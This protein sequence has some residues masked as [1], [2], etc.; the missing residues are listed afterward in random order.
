MSPLD[1]ATRDELIDLLAPFL[2]SESDRRALLSTALFGVP[3]LDQINY[4]SAT[5]TFTTDLIDK[6]E[7]YSEIEPGK[8]ALWAVLEEVRRKV[9]VDKQRRI[10]ALDE[11]ING[12]KPHLTPPGGSRARPVKV[13]IIDDEE[14]WQTFIAK[15]LERLG[16]IYHKVNNFEDAEVA[17]KAAEA[18][19]DP[20]AVVTVDLVFEVG[21]P[22]QAVPVARYG[23][24]M[25]PELKERYP[26]L[27]C[28]VITHLEDI[29][30]HQLL[31]WRDDYDLDYCIFKTHLSKEVLKRGIER[32][33]ARTQ[34]S[35]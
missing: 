13:L 15:M 3:V 24:E 10:D 33:L 26:Y 22:R 27:G 7:A 16:H 12:P 9:G 18:A 14:D 19:G 32:A 5:D 8:K 25:L 17:L 29:S 28:V 6:L 31:D 35:R 21:G 11:S 4:A 23:I 20:F 30:Y 1:R 34:S 2:K